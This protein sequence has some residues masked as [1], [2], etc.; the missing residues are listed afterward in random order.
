MKEPEESGA[1]SES[2]SGRSLGLV[3]ERRVVQLE[4][5]ERIAQRLVL[6]R[7]R[8][9]EAG[10]HE[11]SNRLVAGQRFFGVVSGVEDRVSR[12]GLAHRAHAR[13]HVSYFAR[14]E[15]IGRN[16]SQLIVSDF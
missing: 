7:V 14:P 15:L 10:E 13:Y 16:L 12:A 5:L 8:G 6:G 2:E 1:E 9:V 4:L 11:R 3:V